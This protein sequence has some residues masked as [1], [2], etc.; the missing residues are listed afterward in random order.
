MVI[1]RYTINGLLEWMPNWKRK[2]W[3]TSKG[4]AV[5][6]KVLLRHAPDATLAL[7]PTISSHSP[8]AHLSAAHAGALAADGC[9]TACLQAGVHFCAL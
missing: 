3:K 1:G 2:G 7:A 6:N 5:M 8:V 4:T 9:G